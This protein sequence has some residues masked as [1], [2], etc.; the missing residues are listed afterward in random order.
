MKKE[1]LITCIDYSKAFDS[2]K[3]D[4]IIEALM[5]YRIHLKIIDTIAKI[6]QND[7][8]EIQIGELKKNINI[9]SGR[10]Q[11]CTGSTMLFK[12]ITYMII[13]ELNRRRT[14]Y[15]DQNVNIEFLY[16]ADDGLLLAN[17]IEDLK[18]ENCHTSQ[19]GIWT[20]N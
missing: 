3:R 12:L 14:G 4:T 9:T 5:H 6:Y 19:Q 1:L 18:G 10:R 13:S 15:R 7:F 11:G 2:I 17:S 16:F 20:R 8:S